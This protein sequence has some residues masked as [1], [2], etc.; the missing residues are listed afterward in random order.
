MKLGFGISAWQ[1][2]GLVYLDRKFTNVY[3]HRIKDF[4]VTKL[5]KNLGLDYGTVANIYRRDKPIRINQL[6]KSC[7]MLHIDADFAERS[8]VAFT[9]NLKTKY[10]VKFPI[11]ITPLSL[12]LVSMITGDGSMTDSSALWTQHKSRIIYGA[13]FLKECHG[14]N[15]LIRLSIGSDCCVLSLPKF[16]ID[17]MLQKLNSESPKNKDFFESVINLPREWQFQVFAQIVVDEGSPDNNFQISQMTAKTAD[18]IELLIKSLD[19]RYTRTSRG[20]YFKTE[21]F[22]AIKADFEYAL[23][24]YGK[25]GGFWFKDKR[26]NRACKLIDPKFSE[27]LRLADEKFSDALKIIKTRKKTFNYKDIKKFSN[28]SLTPI[29]ARMTKSIESGRIVRLDRNLYTFP[30]NLKKINSEWLRKTKEEKVLS[31]IKQ[32]KIAKHEDILKLSNLSQTQ[33]YRAINNLLNDGK[34]SRVTRNIYQ[35]Q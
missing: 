1:L 15:S 29:R 23:K 21:S 28:I 22:P 17:G 10:Y 24:T 3:Q 16:F 4:G 33:M 11:K 7:K 31:V 32:L 19:Y 25:F 20:F 35:S 14:F 30:E 26:F 13:K 12:R 8:I 6:Q 18:G 9:Q 34:I 2:D 5:S 27:N